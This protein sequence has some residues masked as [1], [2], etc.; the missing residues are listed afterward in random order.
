MNSVAHS[1]FDR[2]TCWS[3]IAMERRAF[4]AFLGAALA[5]RPTSTFAQQARLRTVGVLMGIANDEEAQARA[6]VIEQGLAKR[7][8]IV[9]QNLS[10]EYRFAAGDIERML[11]LSKEL[12][13]LHPDVIIGHSTP[14]VAALQQVTRTI[15]IIFVV[16]ADPVGS[17]FVTSLARPGGNITGFTNLQPTIT[18]KYLAILRELQPQLTRTGLMYN[19]ESVPGGGTSFMFTFMESAKEFHITPVVFKIHN[20]GEIETAMAELGAVPGS[21]LIVMPDNFTTF[22]RKS[23]IPLATRWQIPTIYPYRYFVDEGGLLSYGIDVLDLFRRA[24]DYVDRILQ[25]AKA[26]DLPV[27]A[28]KKF[29][30]VINLKTARELGLTVP[31]I[32]LAGADA[33]IE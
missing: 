30:L 17:G 8:W 14:V 16:V 24:P 21:G 5:T 28:P 4:V 31:R 29:E 20:P 33:L 10:I 26:A 12:V 2:I 25:G 32:L 6:K 1:R 9:G 23:I 27:Q 3:L 13:A 15:P 19:P 11:S 18:G 22:Y 7:G